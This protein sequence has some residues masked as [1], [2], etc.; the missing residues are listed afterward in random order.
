M[1]TLN[2]IIKFLTTALVLTSCNTKH[3]SI[4]KSRTTERQIENVSLHSRQNEILNS[5]RIISISDSANHL[6]RINIFPLD[7][8][9]FSIQD[10]FTGRASRIEVIGKLQGFRRVS[11]STQF[12]V[13]NRREV[14]YDSEVELNRKSTGRTKVLEKKKN[15]SVLA[16]IG[17]VLVMG[18]IMWKLKR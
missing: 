9:D 2:I 14:D 7:T 18:G 6:Y 13:E 11:D 15:I 4:L 10:G 3:L 8:F 5:N 17:V 16:L 1:K 12:G